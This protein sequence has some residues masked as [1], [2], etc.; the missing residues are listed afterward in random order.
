LCYGK[1]KEKETALKDVDQTLLDLPVKMSWAGDERLTWG[2][3]A[4]VSAPGG[5]A[6]TSGSQDKAG[7]QVC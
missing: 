7:A 6:V 1:D 5:S 3:S 2:F 4:H